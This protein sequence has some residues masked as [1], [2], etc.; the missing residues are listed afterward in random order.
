MIITKKALP[1]RTFLRGMGTTLALP[2]LDAMV[3]AMSAMAQTPANPVRRLG[4]LYLPNGVA[5]NH[6]GIDYWKP[7][8]GETGFELSPILK[9]LE[10]YREQMVAISGLSHGQAESL[11]D[12]NGDHTRSTATWL[13]GVHPNFTQGADVRAGVTADQLAAAA[14]GQE[15]PLPSIEL[16]VDLNFLVGNCD[17]GY[18]CTYL[19]TLSWRTATAPLP[20]E[21]NPRA[22]FERMFGDGGTREQR[23]AETRKDRSILDSVQ[24]DMQRLFQRVGSRDRARADEYFDAVREV[25]RRLQKAETTPV[26]LDLDSGLTRPPVGIPDDFG[27]HV[28]LMFDLQWLAYQADITRVF[29]FMYGREVGS[30]T[31]PEIGLIGGHHAMSHHGDRPEAIERY[32]KLNTYQ[33][34]LFRYF[35]DRLA[36]TPDGDGTLLDHCLLLYGAGM[37]NPNIHSHNDIPLLLVGGASGHLEGGRHL[38]TPPKT[39]MTNLL[40]SMLDKSGVPVDRLGDSS[41]HVDLGNA[42]EPLSGV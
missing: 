16:A 11:G 24:T 38:V 15:T 34:D 39:P 14:F 3:P 41:G 22:V 28:R 30:R 12:G 29:T 36:S 18:S 1:R 27:E 2:L 6:T 13:N 37:S 31:Y 20:T 10:P 26:E 4:F 9:P 32:A 35:V 8:G 5:M 7:T 25:E 17:N 40:V 33:T 23:L 19:N 21:N 42:P